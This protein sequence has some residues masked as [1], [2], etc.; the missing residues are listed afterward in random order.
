MRTRLTAEELNRRCFS[1]TGRRLG[2]VQRWMGATLGGLVE[3]EAAVLE[4]KFMLPSAFAEEERRREA[5]PQLQHN[6]ARDLDPE[7]PTCRS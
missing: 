4:A 7:S 5:Q 1:E 6:M 3:E 2:A